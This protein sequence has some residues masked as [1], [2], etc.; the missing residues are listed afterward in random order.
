MPTIYSE[1]TLPLPV[2]L[3]IDSYNH[4]VNI[5]DGFC[6]EIKNFV[7][8]KDRLVSRQGF[9]PPDATDTREAFDVDY[10]Y[11]ARLPQFTPEMPTAIWS[12][13]ASTWMIKQFDP[14]DPAALTV[15]ISGIKEFAA[16][17]FFTGACAYLDR[18]YILDETGINY[19]TA[20]DWSAGTLTKN[21]VTSTISATNNVRGL[22]NFKERIWA[23]DSTKIYY[24]DAPTSPG[25]Y[26]ETWDVN[27]KFIVVN[28]GTGMG[29]IYQVIPVGTKL[30]IFTATGLYNVSILGS[31]A[32]WVVRLIDTNVQVNTNH[33]AYEVQGMMYFVDTRGVWVTNGDEIHLLSNSIQDAFR[34]DPG[35]NRY[36]KW[37]L[38]PFEDGFLICREKIGVAGGTLIYT[39]EGRLWYTELEF[40][41]WTEFTFTNANEGPV[42]LIGSFAH[43][44]THL[45]WP[46]SSYIVLAHGVSPDSPFT[47]HLLK[48]GGYQDVLRK[49]G[50]AASTTSVI[51]DF[52]TK[53]YRGTMLDEKNGKMAYVNFSCESS[54]DDDVLTD[55]FSYQWYT[56][57]EQEALTTINTVTLQ[58]TKECL[59]PIFGPEYFRHIQLYFKATLSTDM[60][61]VTVL[62]AVL[63]IDTHRKTARGDS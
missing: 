2:G 40:I 11:Y 57:N 32:N 10:Q 1:E 13:G 47:V 24:T 28:A 20:I 63:V 60:S 54:D 39:G 36:F 8:R 61:Q 26:P 48:Y 43:M 42:C 46:K 21:L 5:A 33:C 12:S 29:H 30:F 27:G 19:I 59:V 25:A 23:W 49:L 16:I 45:I 38:T 7:A 51:S 17:S 18:V 3:G 58:N 56:E 9:A 50:A 35:A 41:A 31:P 34:E 22:F 37:K 44:E 15:G 52:L 6:T 62:G 53:I 55:V 14:I 4:P